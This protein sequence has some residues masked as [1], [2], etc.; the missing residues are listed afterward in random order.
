MHIFLKIG[1]KLRLKKLEYQLII[2]E[3]KQESKE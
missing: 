2:F 3:Q 1:T